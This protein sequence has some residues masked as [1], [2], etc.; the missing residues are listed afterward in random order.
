MKNNKSVKLLFRGLAALSFILL[1]VNQMQIAAIAKVMNIQSLPSLSVNSAIKLSGDLAQDAAKVI[2]ISGIPKVYGAELNVEYAHPSQ[3][4]LM[5]QMIDRLAVF[6]PT[7]GRQKI[8]LSGEPLNRYIDI[9]LRIACEYC[10]SAQTMVTSEGQAAC[11]CAHSQAMR[12][13][14]AYL[15]QNHGSEYT[16]DQILQELARWKGLFFPKQMMQKYISQ[17]NS[18]QYSADMAALVMG[19]KVKSNSGQNAPLPTDL[20]LPDMSGGC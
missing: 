6:D 15:L 7:Y 10:C 12:G 3:A 20:S 19:L 9:G 18:G 8:R 16:N 17:V 14:A 4:G 2:L 5:N 13:L 11:G 1:L